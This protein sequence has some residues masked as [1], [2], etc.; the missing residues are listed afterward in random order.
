M[1]ITT[2]N[3]YVSPSSQDPSGVGGFTGAGSLW[4]QT[5]TGVWLVRNSTNTAWVPIGSGD[6]QSFGLMPASGGAMSGAVSGTTNLMTADGNTPFAI[7]PT[8]TSKS[9]LLA[10]LADLSTL[11]NTILT[12]INEIVTQAVAGVSIPS[13]YTSLSFATT[14]VG[15][16]ITPTPSY[17]TTM[18]LPWQ[19]MIYG[20]GTSVQQSECHGFA[21]INAYPG[22]NG[23]TYLLPQDSQG[24]S[25]QCYQATTA[26]PFNYFIV[27]VKST[28]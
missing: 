2:A 17:N 10:S 27:A 22:G 14:S 3:I 11:Q 9:S 12:L 5:D 4:S 19:T 6:Q 13:L 25:W 28:A 20:D 24:L 1:A 16:P 7:P 18:S 23:V 21:C 15:G 26:V 8:I